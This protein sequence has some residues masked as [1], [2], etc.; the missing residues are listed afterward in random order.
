MGNM[1][2]VS[3]GLNRGVRAWDP[4]FRGGGLLPVMAE[5]RGL[6][7]RWLRLYG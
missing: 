2:P 3:L 4:F 6:P 7:A 1:L 5:P